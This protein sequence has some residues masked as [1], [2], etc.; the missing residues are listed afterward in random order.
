MF[1]YLSKLCTLGPSP[2]IHQ[3]ALSHPYFNSLSEIRLAFILFNPIYLIYS[4]V[5]LCFS[6][7][8]LSCVLCVFLVCVWGFES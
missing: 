5:S 6:D 7:D 1:N 2:V 4:S 3:P 8:P